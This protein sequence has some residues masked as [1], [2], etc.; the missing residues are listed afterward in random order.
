MLD[1][2][3][4][5]DWLSSLFLCNPWPCWV[6]EEGI[7]QAA[8]DRSDCHPAAEALSETYDVRDWV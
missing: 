2:T 4:Q 3:L 7:E 6:T 5:V 1:W 8:R